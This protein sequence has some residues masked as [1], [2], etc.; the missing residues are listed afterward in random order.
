MGL[1]VPVDT[2]YLKTSQITTWNVH[3]NC[4]RWAHP[5]ARIQLAP[6]VALPVI[7]WSR[8]TCHSYSNVWELRQ[9]QKNRK[10][11]TWRNRFYQDASSAIRAKGLTN[12][13]RNSN[14]YRH[15]SEI[16]SLVTNSKNSTVTRT[17]RAISASTLCLQ[18]R[19]AH[20]TSQKGAII[21]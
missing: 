1:I 17:Y 9:N 19:W 14:L 18:V 15:R 5:Q 10:S 13:S 21:F 2:W 12:P 7:A 8:S 20:S 6:N 3:K 16:S 11:P 4:S